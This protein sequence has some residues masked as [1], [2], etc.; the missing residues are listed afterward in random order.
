LAIRNR[1]IAAHHIKNALK[2]TSSLSDLSNGISK[3]TEVL[4]TWFF[5]GR[6]KA[7][8]HHWAGTPVDSYLEPG[9][10]FAKP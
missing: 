8:R 3:R 1:R 4:T 7:R 9:E 2:K 10:A 6:A 5:K